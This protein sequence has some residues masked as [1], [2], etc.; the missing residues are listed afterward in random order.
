MG[1]YDKPLRDLL[2]RYHDD[3]EDS[4]VDLINDF[5]ND[6]IADYIVN[7]ADDY[8]Y[9]HIEN[10]KVKTYLQLT[11]NMTFGYTE[12]KI[13]II[14]RELNNQAEVLYGVITVYDFLMDVLTIAI[15]HSYDLSKFL[16]ALTVVNIANDKEIL[17]DDYD[18]DINHDDPKV[19]ETLECRVNAFAKDIL[20]D[21]IDESNDKWQFSLSISTNDTPTIT[22]IPQY[23]Q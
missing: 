2:L 14:T 8:I 7:F 13:P 1:D 19:I 3:F 9:G 21:I 18:D 6:E 12:D 11:S 5:Q 22:D 4:V 15:E 20:K 17:D 23:I 16:L 10:K